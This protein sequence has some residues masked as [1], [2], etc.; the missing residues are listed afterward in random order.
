MGKPER[1][2]SLGKSRRRWVDNIKWRAVVKAVMNLWAPQN[3]GKFS[4]VAKAVASRVVLSSI[5]LVS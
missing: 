2:K 4:M 3:A 1:K 5:E